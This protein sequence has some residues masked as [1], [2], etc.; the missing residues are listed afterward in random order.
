MSLQNK[1]VQDQHLEPSYQ[2]IVMVLLYVKC[3]V[4]GELI[5]VCVEVL[6]ECV[7]SASL[8]VGKS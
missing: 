4:Q 2:N 3:Y 1:I 6:N 7:V 8:N 5:S